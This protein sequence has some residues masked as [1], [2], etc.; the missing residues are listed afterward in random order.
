MRTHTHLSFVYIDLSVVVIILRVIHSHVQVGVK[1]L[2]VYLN[3]ADMVNDP[4]M[5]ELVELEIRETL[6]YYKYDCNDTPIIVG[7]ALCALEVS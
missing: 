6:Q 3:K 4:E 5:M 2:V 7:S 1:K